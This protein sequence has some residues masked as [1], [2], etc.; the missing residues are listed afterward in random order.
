MSS[1]TSARTAFL[2]VILATFAAAADKT[3]HTYLKGTITGWQNGM[4]LWGAGFF[5]TYGEGVPREKTVFELK[6]TDRIYLVDYCGAFQAGQFGLG[7]AV[8][9]RLDADRLYIH[10]ENGKEYK[11]KIEGQKIPQE[12]KA[13][14]PPDKP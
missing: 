6:G 3:P 2:L 7:Q 9:Y 1:V 8:D 12:A 10:R 14:A 4:D 13:V 11:C 5:G